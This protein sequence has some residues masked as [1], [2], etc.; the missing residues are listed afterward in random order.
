MATTK[1]LSSNEAAGGAARV[2]KRHL[3][4]STFTRNSVVCSQASSRFN[5]FRASEPS[6]KSSAPSG[7]S[8][9]PC[10]VYDVISTPSPRLSK[11]KGT[12]RT[13]REER[14][15]LAFTRRLGRDDALGHGLPLPPAV[16]PQ[17]E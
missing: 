11:K 9:Q 10:V 1:R 4:S 3:S 16:R 6:A 7:A 12:P 17:R 13:N 8:R 14:V 2:G 15:A 5:S